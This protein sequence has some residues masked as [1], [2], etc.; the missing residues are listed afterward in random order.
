MNYMESMQ[1]EKKEFKER[2]DLAIGRIRNMLEDTENGL[3]IKAYQDYFTE[4]AKFI[5][6]IDETRALLESGKFE[7]LALEEL[8]KLNH[9]N[10][11]YT[12]ESM[13]ETTYLNPTY[14]VSMLGEEF[15][16]LFSFLFTEIQGMIASVYEYK[17]F[18][19]TVLA[20]LFIEV[21]NYIEEES[22]Y[23]NI[24][25]AIYYHFRDYLD[26]MIDRGIRE[27]LDPTFTL[28]TDLI[29][30]ADQNDVRYLYKFGEYV[31]ENEIKTAQFL[32]QFSEDEIEMMASTY[33]E[34]YRI[35]FETARIDLSK[36]STVNIRYCLGFERMVRAAIKQFRKM[37]LNV[38]F[39]RAGVSRVHKR[40]HLKNGYYSPS[41]NQQYEYDHR[42]DDSIYLD[43]A[44][45]DRRLVCIKKVYEEYKDLAKAYAGPAV[46]EIFGEKSFEPVNKKESMHLT[47]KQQKL[48]LQYQREASVIVNQYI[49]SDETS[50]TIIAYPI[51]EIGKDFENIFQETVKVN[52]LDMNQYRNIQQSM[53]D[54]LDQGE[55]VYIK[56]NKTN[57][58]DLKV[59]L[60]PLQ[61]PEKETNF[62]NC[63]A[64]VNIPVGEVFTSPQLKGTEGILHV[65][66]V[67]L[68][69]LRYYDLKICFKDGM[70]E[71]Y[72]CKNFDSDEEN[73]A[74][75]KE[76]LL[77]HHETLPIG[78]FAI[79]T[80]TTA[81]RMG[82]KFKIQDKLP[83][84]IA[85][86]TGP[87]FA[88]GDTCYRMSEENRVYNPDGK[89]IV[90]KDNEC[91]LLRKT[92]LEKAYFNCHT[93]ITIPYDELGEITVFYKTGQKVKIIE[94]GRFVLS[95]TEEL[96]KAL[97]QE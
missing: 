25:D 91:S 59:M 21:Y 95:G 36:K 20:E 67:Y 65:S 3:S 97:E 14:A 17:Y 8:Q 43:K 39:C 34:G 71:A 38:T 7:Q 4:V 37:G 80:N 76:N 29:L 55:Y 90:A 63:L 26:I 50:F 84:L 81:Y 46:I 64:D 5:I 58:T 6:K 28:V 78:E 22:C 61:N 49:R 62:E 56:G 82:Q 83:I 79:G 75:I 66:E 85:E 51:P 11:Y 70:I 86:K 96:N 32:N 93:D 94:N 54:V 35:G 88:V 77:Y 60:H 16:A 89:E 30:N 23:Q 19:M 57:M 27:L 12:S 15:G 2:Y 74:Y 92:D 10:Y 13:Y 18:E 9:E 40:Q 31:T 24:K 68:R 52:T 42:F 1:E 45:I 72:H 73:K 53:I 44:F 47:E 48:A 87:H 33:T 69:D 41:Y